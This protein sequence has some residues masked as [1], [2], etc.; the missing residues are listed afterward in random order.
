MVAVLWRVQRRRLLVWVLASVGT[1]ALTATAV[2]RLYDT[3]EKIASYGAALVSDALIASNGHVEG[4]DT[5]GASF[6]T[7]SGS[8]PPS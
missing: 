8:S 7:S 6:R 1:L 4:I 2:A 5:L 3:P